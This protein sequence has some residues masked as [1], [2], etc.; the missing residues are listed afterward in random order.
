MICDNKNAKR[1][2]IPNDNIIIFILKM[3]VLLNVKVN[4]KF[5]KYFL[6]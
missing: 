2:K 1:E 4:H 3:F 6:N 5:N